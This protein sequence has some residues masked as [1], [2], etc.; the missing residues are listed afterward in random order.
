MK[1]VYVLL[2]AFCLGACG[3]NKDENKESISQMP[4]ENDAADYAPVEE[5]KKA[6][7]S[8][9]AN[10]TEMDANA[11]ISPN[12]PD[13]VVPKLIRTADLRFQVN[14]LE[15]SSEIIDRLVKENGAYVS[16]ANMSSTNSESNNTISIRVPNG[17]FD[18]LL[19]SICKESVYMER[20]NV[21]TQDVTEEYIDIEARLKTKKEVEARY[22]EILKAKAKTVDE[23]LR[24]EEQIRVIREEIEAREGRLN[25]LK[26][27][28]SYSTI[29]VQVYQQIEYRE[30]P[31]EV[32]DSFSNKASSGF[33]Q[34]WDVV[35]NILLGIITIWPVW[36]IGAIIYFVIRRQ[37][38]NAKKTTV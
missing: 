37:L 6:D 22:I 34:G 27:Q 24:A 17:Q 10:V 19:K 38:K 16:T 26:N 15:K 9:A 35:K 28:V 11:K 4:G 32:T 21:S 23:V 18:M 30:N 8:A 12:L 3:A 5:T 33:G 14:D 7:I 1:T 13:V 29:I 25:Y 31:V 36:I 20:K 2:M